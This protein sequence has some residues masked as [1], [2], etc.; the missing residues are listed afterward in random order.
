MA[1]RREGVRCGEGVPPNYGCGLREGKGTLPL[2]GHYCHSKCTETP[3]QKKN[4]NSSF[5][6]MCSRCLLS[7]RTIDVDYQATQIGGLKLSPQI[8]DK[9]PTAQQ[10]ATL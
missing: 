5:E 6:M 10:T 8:V 1:D 4:S 9:F 7:G 3:L 2:P